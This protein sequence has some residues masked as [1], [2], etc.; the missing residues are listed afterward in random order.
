M[1]LCLDKYRTTL[2][3]QEVGAHGHRQPTGPLE[4]YMQHQEAINSGLAYICH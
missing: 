4:W 1:S 3:V 2:T